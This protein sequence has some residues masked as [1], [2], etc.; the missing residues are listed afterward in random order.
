MGAQ[1]WNA[2]SVSLRIAMKLNSVVDVVTNSKP[3][4]RRVEPKTG[5]ET[6]FVTNVAAISYL[7]K[8]TH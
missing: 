7:T 6:I 5:L 3:P 2:Q 1:I 8:G 4:A